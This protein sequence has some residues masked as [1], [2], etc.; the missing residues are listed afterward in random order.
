MKHYIRLTLIHILFLIPIV[1]NAQSNTSVS[2]KADA[3]V[4]DKSEIELITIKDMELNISMAVNG[5]ISIS[6]LRDSTVAVMMVKGKAGADFRVSFIPV[7]EIL[8][9]SG[10][11]T[12]LL[13]YEMN[14]YPSDN[15][16][17][18]EPID[19]AARTLKISNESKYFFWVGGNIDVS[20]AQPGS[21]DGEFTIEI[22]YI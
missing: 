16:G 15:Q 10:K 2:I 12:L 5:K 6:A 8:N 7:I 22:E 17:A 1:L 9:R 3:M 13:H 19:A 11:G 4:I 21:Y 14:G 20:K 18:S